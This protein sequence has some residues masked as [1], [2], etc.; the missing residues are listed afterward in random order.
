M[1]RDFQAIQ[2]SQ[3]TEQ[4]KFLSRERTSKQQPPPEQVG[5][6]KGLSEF[7]MGV[8][9]ISVG[10]ENDWGVDEFGWKLVIPLQLISTEDDELNSSQ[11]F[12][13]Q[14]VSCRYLQ[15]MLTLQYQNQ[16]Q[17]H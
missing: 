7:L 8:G 1:L 3:V 5:G 12:Q 16:H 10:V 2:R 4:K 9:G 17:Q 15:Q 6:M 13:D 14:S 11:I